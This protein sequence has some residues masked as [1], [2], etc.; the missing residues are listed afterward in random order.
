MKRAQYHVRSPAFSTDGALDESGFVHLGSVPDISGF[1][2]WFDNDP[3]VYQPKS[4]QEPPS[5]KEVVSTL[6]AIGQW[7]WGTVQ[8]D[9]NKDQS[10]S[11]I[12]VD[13][14]LGLI[15]LVDQGLD[16][17][18]LIAGLKDII[19]FYSE[20]EDQQSKHPEVLGL[21]Y[22]VWLW[23]GVFLI[24]IGCIPELGS[25]VKGVLKGLIRFLQDA[26]KRVFDL[27]PA[28]LRRLW[29]QLIAILNHVGVQQGNVQ[30]WLKQLPGRLNSLMDEAAQKIRGGLD[31]VREMVTKAEEYAQRLRGTL[32]SEQAAQE[33]IR[34]TQQYKQALTRA[35]NRLDQ[36]KRRVNE[37]IREQLDRVLEGKHNF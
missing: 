1:A 15:P 27:T 35:Y 16:V 19:E 12:A 22:E 11:Q 8:G 34:R 6:D 7:I 29:E 37:W 4:P 36:M 10:V 31:S 32:L 23:I 25:A 9:F 20:D 33:V 18:D 26:A 17:R 28:Q 24:A 14:V 13:T 3:E 2:Y 30:R 21:P 5:Q